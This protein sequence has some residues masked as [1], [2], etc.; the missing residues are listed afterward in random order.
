VHALLHRCAIVDG[1]THVGENGGDLLLQAV[2]QLAI[3]DAVDLEVDPGFRPTAG[4][5]TRQRRAAACRRHCA[6]G[7][8]Q[9]MQQT[10]DHQAM[11][12]DEHGDRIDE[13]GH[14]VGHDIDHGVR[15]SASR[16]GRSPACRGRPGLPRRRTSPR[17]KC[18]TAA[19]RSSSGLASLAPLSSTSAK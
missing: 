13:E 12:I 7:A 6:L 9:G 19:P 4:R 17:R 10:M 3:A 5:A 11:A 14:V 18:C 2:D 1:G 8:E 16:G 15:R